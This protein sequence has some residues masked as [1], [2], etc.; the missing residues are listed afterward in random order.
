MQNKKI[1]CTLC[2]ALLSACLCFATLGH[3]DEHPHQRTSKW[4]L[5]DRLTITIAS[6]AASTQALFTGK[7][8]FLRPPGGS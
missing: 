4:P 6:T 3:A 1:R 7:W 8:L 5:P 2:G